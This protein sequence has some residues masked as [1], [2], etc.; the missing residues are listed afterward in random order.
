MEILIGILVMAVFIGLIILFNQG[1]TKHSNKNDDFH[2]F[3]AD[4]ET[5]DE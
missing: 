3:Y 5:D 4:D 1:K 2:Y